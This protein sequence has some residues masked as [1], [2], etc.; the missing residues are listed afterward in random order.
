MA[1]AE[2]RRYWTR[3]AALGC[4]VCRDEFETTI[5]HVHG[6]SCSGLSGMGL[7]SNDWLVIPLCK[8]HHT[9][10]AGIQ[11]FVFV[12]PELGH[13]GQMTYPKWRHKNGHEY[14]S[15]A[16]PPYATDW[17]WCGPLL[18]KYRISLDWAPDKV[19]D[20]GSWDFMTNGA[21]G[22]ADTPQRAIC[23]AVIAA[24]PPAPP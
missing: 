10:R 8:N 18:D 16:A 6:G 1:T 15:E 14:V 2:I 11:G 13:Y 12:P 3:V 19:G 9:G 21:E 17:A 22:C 23:L 5:H 24:K 7:K 4:Y 20:G